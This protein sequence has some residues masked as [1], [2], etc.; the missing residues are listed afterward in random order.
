MDFKKEAVSFKATSEEVLA[1]LQYCV[2]LEVQRE[3]A[4]HFDVVRWKRKLERKLQELYKTLKDQVAM[5][6]NDSSKCRVIIHILITRLASFFDN[7]IIIP[8]RFVYTLQ[9]CKKYSGNFL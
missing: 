1:I 2:Q 5:H 7:L 3:D 9:K 8:F 4:R 6:H